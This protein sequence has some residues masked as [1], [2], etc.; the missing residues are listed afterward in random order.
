MCL[1]VRVHRQRLDLY[2]QQEQ[3][4]ALMTA[5]LAE[6]GLP[7]VIGQH[8]LATMQ[9]FMTNKLR[10]SD[11][12]N[13]ALAN[14]YCSKENIHLL[15]SSQGQLTRAVCLDYNSNGGCALGANCP[16]PHGCPCGRKG[17]HNVFNCWKMKV[18]GG[19]Q[20]FPRNNN[21]NNN[22]TSSRGGRGGSRRGR[23]RGR[24]RG[25]TRQGAQTDGAGRGSTP[26]IR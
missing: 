15:N 14:A 16:L 17:P 21:N 1:F 13:N 18:G 24:G 5:Q 23:G 11:I 8:Y 12:M 22:S 6:V 26:R 4:R 3:I 25:R 20:W 7:H 2:E 9:P 10:Y 19:G